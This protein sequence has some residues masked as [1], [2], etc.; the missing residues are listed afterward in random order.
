MVLKW[1][2]CD[3]RLLTSLLLVGAL[4]KAPATLLLAEA[5]SAASVTLPSELTYASFMRLEVR[6]LMRLSGL[7]RGR[8]SRGATGTRAGLAARL[9]GLTGLARPTG[10]TELTE[11]TGLAGAAGG[12]VARLGALI[13]A[14]ARTRVSS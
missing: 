10:L 3:R 11:L 9:A 8:G 6:V 14:S 7:F 1:E 12:V 5:R 2:I 4:R 13:P